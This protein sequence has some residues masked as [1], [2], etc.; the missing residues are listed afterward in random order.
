MTPRRLGGP[1]LLIG[2]LFAAGCLGEPTASGARRGSL[3]LAPVFESPSAVAQVAH[4]RVRLTRPTSGAAVVDEV[5]D[6]APGA[7]SV[8]ITV[9]VALTSASEDFL[10]YVDVLDAAGQTLFRNDPYPRRVTV[11]AGGGSAT[12]VAVLLRATVASVV[13]TPVTATLAALGAMQ[14][15]TAV[16]LDVSGNP[17]PR[18][19][20]WSTSDATVASVNPATGEATAVGNGTV[21]ITAT[22]DG[23]SG[24]G[25]LTVSQVAAAITL[26]SG[27]GQTATVGA[28]LPGLL[29]VQVTD[30]FGN[31]LGGELVDWLVTAGGGTVTPA[32]TTTDPGGFASTQWTLGPVAGGN[33]AHAVSGKLAG[34]PVLFTATATPVGMTSMWLGGD[35]TTPTDWSTAGNWSTGLVPGPSDNVFIPASAVN[36]PVLSASSPVGD[37]VLESGASLTIASTATLSVGGNLDAGTTITGAGTVELAGTGRTAKGTLPTVIVTG[38]VSAAGGLTV[39]GDLTIGAIVRAGGNLNLGGQIVTVAANF[40]TAAGGVLIMQSSAD[41]LAVQGGASFGGGSETGLLTAGTLRV[42]GAFTKAG[43]A[44][45]AFAGSGAHLVVLDGGAAQSV[46]IDAPASS[47]FQHLQIANA[48]AMDILPTTGIAIDGDLLVSSGAFNLNGQTVTVAGNFGTTGTGVLKMQNARDALDVGGGAVFA[49]APTLL[50]DGVLRVSGDFT[51][52]LAGSP[53][54]FEGAG[55]HV[56]E[57]NGT[58][59]QTVGF[60]DPAAS[61]FGNLRI[62]NAS[63]G[64]V[65]LATDV[66]GAGQLQTPTDATTRAVSGVGRT[67]RFFGLDAGNLVLDGAP[68]VVQNGFSIVRFDSVTFTKNY[69]LTAIQLTVQ[70][71][72]GAFTF[73]FL[74]FLTTPTTGFFVSATDTAPTDPNVLTILMANSPQVLIGP[75]YTVTD[76]VAMVQWQ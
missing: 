72:G 28:A 32:T 39:S 1:G 73:G 46:S 65:L 45:D 18:S 5:F 7:T 11:T 69:G 54:S 15:F 13:V 34:S 63:L 59:A 12:P 44:A 16:A 58:A 10:L 68:L 53:N 74:Q 23:V 56:T 33:T 3:A 6:V 38:S 48:A 22:T 70:R 51:Q 8:D 14:V 52:L 17:L 42:G 27:D 20:A 43:G 36:Q 57:L 37:L 60:Q 30:L 75:R 41:V 64:G 29:V 66:F 47:R 55:L 2:V 40:A 76:G 49:G 35:P 50:I 26:V 4:V 71:D 19:F 61:H 9:V 25:T 31:G 21:M 24:S 62:A 67:M